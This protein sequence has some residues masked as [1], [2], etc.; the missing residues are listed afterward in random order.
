MFK[1]IFIIIFSSI[2]LF[3]IQ[4]S[5]SKK[6][7][8]YKVVSGDTIFFIA[9]KFKV[10]ISDIYKF[11]NLKVGEFIHPGDIIKIPPVGYKQKAKKAVKE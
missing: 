8:K 5:N 6:I 1:K 3:G 2:L 11:N 7:K 10:S 9:K 4:N